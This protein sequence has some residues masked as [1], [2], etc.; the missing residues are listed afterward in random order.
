V[1]RLM[2]FRDNGYTS[3]LCNGA[4]GVLDYTNSL[5]PYDYWPNMLFDA[6]EGST[7]AEGTGD[8]MDMGGLFSYVAIDANNLR[9]WFAGNIGTT[10][11]QAL[12]N[13]GYIIYFSDRRGDHDETNGDVETGEY[14]HEDSINP[15]AATWA[16]NNVLDQGEDFNENGTEK[17]HTRW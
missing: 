8:G 3:N 6:R 13:N 4:N 7:R 15:A 2:R 14:G 10:G 9:R 1:I 11:T 16:K 12:N 5:D 17:R